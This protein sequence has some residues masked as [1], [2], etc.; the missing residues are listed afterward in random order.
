MQFGWVIGMGAALAIGLGAISLALTRR[1]EWVER[2]RDPQPLALAA[3]EL[4]SE[5]DQLH[6]RYVDRLDSLAEELKRSRSNTFGPELTAAKIVGVRSVS[7]L[8]LTGAQTPVHFEVREQERGELPF[9]ADRF[10]PLAFTEE[11]GAL[12]VVD[13]TRIVGSGA[14]SGWLRNAS[15]VFYYWRKIGASDIM[16]AG[17]DGGSIRRA[18]SGW[19]SEEEE[20]SILQM[21]SGEGELTSLAAPDGTVIYESGDTSDN[22]RAPQIFP[23]TIRFGTWQIQAW[24]AGEETVRWNLSYL[25][26]GMSLSVLVL[27]GS[28]A[29]AF[30]LRRAT[31]LAGQRVSFVNRASHELRTPITNMMLNVDL[32]H[33]LVDEDPEAARNRLDRVSGEASRLSRLVDNL[34]TFSRSEKGTDRI[35]SI[36]LDPL[37]ILKDVLAQ[38]EK[39]F[40]DRNIEVIWKS[41]DPVEVLADPDALAQ[42]FGNLISNVEKYAA[43]G[44]VLEIEAALTDQKWRADFSDRGPGISAKQATRIFE[45]FHRASDQVNEGVSGTGL[46]LAIAR[47]LSQRMGGKLELVPS[48]EGARFRLELPVISS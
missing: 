7:V 16:I 8:S 11:E 43:A 37:E 25:L 40:Q 27:F 23:A 45:P 10:P 36:R 32:A 20:L 22:Q 29:T 5:L 30:S 47:D 2:P 31:R 1:T 17:V 3:E 28:V 6:S 14:A 18:I 38:F 12:R 26:A 9:D 15:D 41:E 42:V 39:T 35:H 13:K 24:S 21:R 34:L 46:G 44:G 4:Q 33:E 19:L 48:N